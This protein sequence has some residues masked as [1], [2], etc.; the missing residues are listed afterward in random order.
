MPKVVATIEARMTS[1]RLPGK[2]LLPL[3]DDPALLFMIKQLQHCKHIDEIAVATTTNDTDTP[4]VE[5]CKKHNISFFRG[6]EDDVLQRVLDTALSVNADVIVELT[7][8]CPLIDPELVDQSVTHYLSSNVD[9][10]Y[11]RLDDALPDGLDVEIFS[12][13]L[14]Q[15]WNTSITDPIDRVHVSSFFRT[16]PETFS[17][18]CPP[19]EKESSLIWPELGIT[20]D[21]KEDYTTLQNIV[22]KLKKHNGHIAATDVVSLLKHQ[23]ELIEN[24]NVRRKALHE[25]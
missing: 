6:S 1:S 2:V 5:L 7:G 19:I 18:S 14:L 8:D 16:R 12:T 22:T 4:I 20:L 17:H 24:T 25:G 15:K 10:V 3:G 23:P 9:Y 13:K 11:N 21:T